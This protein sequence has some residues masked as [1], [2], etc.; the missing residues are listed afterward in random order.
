MPYYLITCRSLTYAQ[1]TA[2]VLER[3]GI[4]ARVQRAP[5]SIAEE[6]CG[7]CVRLAERDLK[8]A[9]QQLSAAELPVRHIYAVQPDG[10]LRE[11]F[12]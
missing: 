12:L 11:V 3:V 10:S 1:R 2:R 9:V 4:R 6:G 8:Q 7:Y 5:A